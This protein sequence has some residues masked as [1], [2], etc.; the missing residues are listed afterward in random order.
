[1]V[2]EKSPIVPVST[3]CF[4]MARIINNLFSSCV[5]CRI[6]F[7]PPSSWYKLYKV[8]SVISKPDVVLIDLHYIRLIS[9]LLIRSLMNCYIFLC[10]LDYILH[11]TRVLPFRNAC[12]YDTR[13]Y[14]KYAFSSRWGLVDF[15]FN[16]YLLIA[17]NITCLGFPAFK[18]VIAL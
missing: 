15:M 17:Y 1:M 14:Y 6:V 10:R 8:L 13:S 7:C 18:K 5:N 16:S 11:V 2:L 3:I 4:W 12:S 9:L